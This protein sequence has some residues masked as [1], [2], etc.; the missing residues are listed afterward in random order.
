M[1]AC[2]GAVL[3]KNQPNALPRSAG[4]DSNFPVTLNYIDRF[5]AFFACWRFI[6]ASS[7]GD[8]TKIEL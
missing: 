5:V 3:K 7:A 8:A 1:G 6:I 2:S 4:V